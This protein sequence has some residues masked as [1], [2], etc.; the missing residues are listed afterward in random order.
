[1][2]NVLKFGCLGLVGLAVLLVALVAVAGSRGG[3]QQAT[4]QAS[5]AKPGEPGRVGQRVESAGI[6][7]TVNEVRRAEALGAIQKAQAGRTFVVA[8][9]TLENA[10][11]DRAPYNPAYFKIRDASGYEYAAQL[12]GPD[13]YLKSGELPAGDRVRGTVAFEVP[14]DARGLVASYQPVVILGGYQVLRVALD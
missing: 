11:R 1:M 9:V 7:L 6:A 3:G 14:A 8:D 12:A 13:A 5:P 4:G 10:T 2:R